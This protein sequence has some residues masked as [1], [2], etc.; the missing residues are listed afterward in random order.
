MQDVP[1]L[2]F[3]K[4]SKRNKIGFSLQL[5]PN[6]ILIKQSPNA[7]SCL[8]A[9]ECSKAKRYEPH[10]LSSGQRVLNGANTT[11]ATHRPLCEEWLQLKKI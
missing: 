4:K 5:K 1:L 2:H 7:H 11:T 6:N 3:K 10:T 9:T 8:T